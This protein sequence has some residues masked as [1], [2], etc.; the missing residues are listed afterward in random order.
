ME[1]A[2]TNRPVNLLIVIPSIV[3]ILAMVGLIFL[4]LTSKTVNVV[5]K[6][7]VEVVK[8][9]P[10][11]VTPI[12]PVKVVPVKVIPVVPSNLNHGIFVKGNSNPSQK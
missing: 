6:S 11:K 10:I 7:P 4:N 1:S 12:V 3:V 8:V 9:D 5:K 2:P